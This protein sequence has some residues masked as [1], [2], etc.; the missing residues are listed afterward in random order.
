MSSAF[1]NS[2]SRSFTTSPRAAAVPQER[3][4][5]QTKQSLDLFAFMDLLVFPIALQFC[6]IGM[7]FGN[8][9]DVAKEIQT[10]AQSTLTFQILLKLVFVAIGLVIGGW[11]WWYRQ[12]VRALL[13][14]LPGTMILALLAWHFVTSPMAMSA[15]KSFIAA[16]SFLSIV[17]VT[18]SMLACFGVR[19]LVMTTLFGIILYVLGSIV[20]YAVSPE[21]ATFK[22]VMNRFVTIERFGGLAHPNMLGKYAVMMVLLTMIAIGDGYL[23]WKWSVP[24][25][26]LA[27]GV[28]VAC[29]SRTPV[30]AG[31]AA[32][33]IVMAP[34]LRKR[35][36]YLA[37]AGC[38]IAGLIGFVIVE[39]TIGFDFVAEKLIAKVTK[40]G[41]A[42]EVTTVTGRTDIWK[43]SLA[44]SA[45]RPIFGWGSASTAV[46]ME[47]MSGHS[48]NLILH[49]ILAMG[50][51]GGALVIVILLMNLVNAIRM[52]S[53]LL[54]GVLVFTL[55]L[56]MVESPLLGSFPDGLTILWIAITLLPILLI[57]D[58]Q[59]DR[60]LVNSPAVD[61]VHRPNFSTAT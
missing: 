18:T 42:E 16:V 9:I 27:A 24:S 7:V 38:M 4:V 43:Y 12:R 52:D 37:I 55:V 45:E 56:G 25:I 19:R 3:R 34:I 40:T 57:L 41:S 22:E 31:V 58:K 20:L 51:P 8:N 30:I 29:L 53:L 10:G 13:T 11:G 39:S 21:M 23:D 28:L 44:R 59:A 61:N 2:R 26:L 6:Y 48:H 5:E 36:T 33:G 47:D 15:F 49:P 54:R 46:V 14:S 17:L 35:E 1:A 32:C 60:G 50:F